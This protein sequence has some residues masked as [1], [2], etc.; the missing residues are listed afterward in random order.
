MATRK[1]R[2]NKKK[3]LGERHTAET[4]PMYYYWD[5]F[6]PIEII[7]L[8]QV[9]ATMSSS[10][11]PAA[12]AAATAAIPDWQPR[13]YA[14]VC[15]AQTPA[16]SG[17]LDACVAALPAEARPLLAFAL[18]QRSSA[19]GSLSPALAALAAAWPPLPRLLDRRLLPL[20]EAED[21]GSDGDVLRL[22]GRGAT[23]AAWRRS[24][25]AGCDDLLLE[26]PLAAEALW[27]LAAAIAGACEMVLSL[28][29]SEML[30]DTNNP[31]DGKLG[32]PRADVVP[33][34]L[35]LTGGRQMLLLLVVNDVLKIHQGA[36][37]F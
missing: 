32:M 20:D 21:A 5:P 7:F 8:S 15:A 3:Y 12:S 11:A 14:A 23:A 28:S 29:L 10:P 27:A 18:W 37:V 2:K 26:P 22:F 31:I 16:Q 4:D 33:A 24:L 17:A 9:F 30:T 25:A 1:K 6:Y 13:A 36:C 19:A 35:K 34:L